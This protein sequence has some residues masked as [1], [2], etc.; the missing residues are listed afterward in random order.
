MATNPDRFPPSGNRL[1][2]EQSVTL[3]ASGKAK[4][5]PTI[6]MQPGHPARVLYGVVTAGTITDAAII[7]EQEGVKIT[8]DDGI[9][10]ETVADLSPPEVQLNRA[11]ILLE[12]NRDF[13]PVLRDEGG[14]GGTWT[15]Q[16]VLERLPTTTQT[17]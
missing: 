7:L 1:F 11:G 10:L 4:L 17:R 5:S 6:R 16:W 2:C 8:P 3:A 15:I 13:E 14:A 12:P 9:P